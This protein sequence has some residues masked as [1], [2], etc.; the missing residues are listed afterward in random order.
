MNFFYYTF[1]VLILIFLPN[2]AQAQTRQQIQLEVSETSFLYDREQNDINDLVTLDVHYLLHYN[3]NKHFLLHVDPRLRLDFVDDN[4]NRY[5]PH[6]AYM[7]FYNDKWDFRFGL[8]KVTWGNGTLFNPTDVINRSDLEANYI[9]REKLSDP[10]VSLI[11]NSANTNSTT[12]VGFEAYAMPLF[13]ETPLP[14]DNSRF[15]L[16]GEQNAIPYTMADSQDSPSYQ[17]SV[18]A[19]VGLSLQN[20][21]WDI[22][23]YYYHGPE[24]DPGFA[25]RV[26]NNGALQLKPFYYNINMLGLTTNITENRITLKT[27]L[28][29]KNTTSNDSYPHDIQPVDDDAIPGNSLE[30]LFGLDYELPP[31]DADTTVKLSL[32]Y[33][34]NTQDQEAYSS[35]ILLQSDVLLAV[36]SNSNNKNGVRLMAGAVKDIGS[37]EWLGLADFSF[38][39]FDQIRLGSQCFYTHTTSDSALSLFDNTSYLK[40]YLSYTWGKQGDK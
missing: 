16:S 33:L 34:G 18:G 39:L 11:F 15:A 23:G 36:T 19:G 1:A 13:M 32:E 26:D 7:G 35:P 8:Q 21:V 37:K 40:G 2:S 25:L 9:L 24:H 28:S 4:R 38:L 30:F 5:Q 20:E 31:P 3:N 6:E 22:R 17:K 29:Y 14:Q 27:A 10:I 12:Q